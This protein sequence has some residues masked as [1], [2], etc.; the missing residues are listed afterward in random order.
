MLTDRQADLLRF[1][2]RYQ[3][4]HDGV[5]PDYREMMQHMGVT[6]RG[7]MLGFLRQL[8]QRMFI[9][10]LPAAKRAISIKRLPDRIEPDLLEQ[11][12]AKLIGA[13]YAVTRPGQ[14]T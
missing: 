4:E 13:G 10:R 6:S 9:E 8:E 3:L 14:P 7:T 12:A 1:I 2:Y 5:S 11:M